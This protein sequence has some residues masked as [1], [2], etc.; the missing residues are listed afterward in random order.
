MTQAMA[1]GMERGRCVTGIEGVDIILGG[2]IPVNST[3]L[4]SGAPGTGKTSLAFEFLARGAVQGEAGLLISTIES[5]QKLL[6]NIPPLDFF[7]DAQLKKGALVIVS[8]DEM[9]KTAGV[10]PTKMDQG[11]IEKLVGAIAKAVSAAKVKRLAIDTI[12]TL[13]TEVQGAV[14][15][16]VLLTELSEMLYKSGCTALLVSSRSAT[17]ALGAGVDGIVMLGNLE[18]RGDTLRTLQVLKMKGTSHSRARYVI[19]LTPAGVL[20]TPLLRG[21]A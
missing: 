4:V 8:L 5:E 18:R 21:G 15:D 9:M 17:G 13:L 11:A 19:D 14:L 16:G 1:K 2:G 10:S 12:D 7:D 3:V 6:S 20:L